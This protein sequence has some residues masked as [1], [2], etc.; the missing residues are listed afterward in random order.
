ML[1]DTA[2]KKAK[3]GD[4][5]YH[6]TDSS[7]LSIFVTPAGAKVW[8]FR[9][10]FAG[11]PKVLSFDAY[12][13]VSLAEA[14]Q[15]R[16]EARK[17]VKA[18]RDPAVERRKLKATPQDPGANT[19]ERIAR[20]WF[21]IQKGTWSAR[22]AADVI[23]SL[24]REVFPDIG[25][26]LITE[27]TP[28]DVLDV[29]RKIEARPAVETAHRVRQRISGVFVFGIAS[30]RC[31]NDP[32]AI[33]QKALSP[34]QK[35]RQPAVA[36]LDEARGIIAALDAEPAHPAT[37]LA[38]RLLALTAVRPGTLITT[39]W[40]ELEE[41]DPEKPIWRI[42]A[43]RMK[44]RKAMKDD[45]RNDHEVPLSLQAVE[46]LQAVH[47][48]TGKGP[49]VFP[50]A[51]HAHKPMSE[52]ALGYLLNRAGY[53]GR[54]VP[55]GWRSTFSTIMNEEFPADRFVIDAMLAHKKKDKVE[56]A[57]N[58]AQHMA[59]RAVL[60][61]KWADMLLEGALPADHLLGGRRKS[62]PALF[63]AIPE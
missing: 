61:Q 63:G 41:I 48:L 17:L 5:G 2:I 50:N 12:P 40:S 53:P 31:V 59:R 56:A 43:A 15:M 21:D 20:E 33:V 37:R 32:A 4:K 26:E 28:P 9:Y 18:G 57:Y 42:P 36:T 23:K 6:L 51:R 16:D 11:K 35:G 34:I 45:D 52:N 55:H 54:H 27:I 1:T 14:R 30:G 7:G 47:K 39:R 46:T 60:A 22:H 13:D 24:E 3:A 58:R 19:F 10:R 38:M 44:L 29:L 49:Y 25:S 8:R 62:A